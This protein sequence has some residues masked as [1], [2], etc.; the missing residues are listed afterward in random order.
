MAPGVVPG[1]SQ[2]FDLVEYW[3]RVWRNK[4]IV[5]AAAIL[6]T[7]LGV[8]AMVPQ[9]RI[10]QARM[11]LEVQTLNENFMNFRDVNPTS[12]GPGL[13]PEIDM[14]TH[15]KLLQTRPLLEAV[16]SRLEQ[17][18]KL[19]PP[20]PPPP[21]WRSWLRLPPAKKE[22]PTKGQK[23]GPSY[24]LA[25]DLRVRAN[26]NTRIIDVTFD[27]PDPEVAAAFVNTLGEEFIRSNL[28]SRWKQ[29]QQTGDWLTRQLHDMKAKL[30]TSETDLQEYA[31]RRN[32][33][34]TGDKN[35]EN[36]DEEKL[37]QIQAEL[38]RAQADRMSKQ[39]RFE[40][41]NATPADS[42]AEVIENESLRLHQQK[43]TELR[44]QHAELDST[45][46]P[47]HYRVRRVKAQVAQLE[48][49]LGRL[50]DNILERIRGDY[51][52]A[53][54]RERLLEAEFKRQTELVAGLS[55]KA[56]QYNILKREVETNRQLYESMLQKVREANLASAMRA[57]GIRIVEPADVPA[58]P[59]KPDLR[60]GGTLGLV[61]GLFLGVGLALLRERLDRCIQG[62]EDLQVYL[63][64]PELG[65][66]PRRAAG[67]LSAAG[68]REDGPAAGGLVRLA[69][70][71]MQAEVRRKSFAQSEAFRTIVT[72][73]LFSGS[74]REAKKVLVVTSP[75]PSEG[76]STLATNVAAAFAEI[77]RKTLVIDA[78]MRRPRV[79]AM[80]GLPNDQGLAQILSGEVPMDGTGLFLALHQTS[81]VGL[82]VLP[83]GTAGEEAGSLVHSA[84]FPDLLALLRPYFDVILIDTPPM[85]QLADARA[86]ASHAD[87]I[88]LVIRSGQTTREAAI[89][90]QRRLEHDGLPIV[91]VVL[92]D[93]DPGRSHY[94]GYAYYKDTYGRY[95][96]VTKAG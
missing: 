51:L 39:S 67:L 37:R 68:N 72:S 11:S 38:S 26:A 45:L 80:F 74:A 58:L 14:L 79:H 60:R 81:L 15:V 96:T 65:V 63:R 7:L 69:A 50:R 9:T 91:G 32:L 56:V 95:A 90:A 19:K 86:V 1:N 92:N 27:S 23:K 55:E 4:W 31:R 6:G 70:G 94:G 18:G 61:A 30:Q 33:M 76:K 21:G 83:S 62:P 73:I 54:S 34:F 8:L 78:D 59:Y 64:V 16:V 40:L 10:Y 46:T 36:V 43:L 35:Q 41:V 2:H 24:N 57:S 85:L 77:G 20:P 12:S 17:E 66:V 87:G 53:K 48:A 71:V 28:E 25:G 3:R 44:R 84:R 29:A 89:A 5:A 42:L 13:Y 75:N 88:V 93:W 22:E 47:E 52:A 82:T 49:E